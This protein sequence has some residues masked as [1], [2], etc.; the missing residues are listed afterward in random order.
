M[1]LPSTVVLALLAASAPALSVVRD[2]G[3]EEVYGLGREVAGNEVLEHIEVGVF[4][5]V[6]DSSDNHQIK[7][8]TISAQMEIV[9]NAFKVANISFVIK[10]METRVDPRWSTGYMSDM[11]WD[12]H[13]GSGRDLNLWILEKAGTDSMR[14]GSVT[15]AMSDSPFDETAYKTDGVVLAAIAIPNAPGWTENSDFQGKA[16]I[17]AIAKWFGLRSVFTMGC[18]SEDS[19]GRPVIDDVPVGRLPFRGEPA[20]A[21]VTDCSTPRDTCPEEPD[22]VK[23]GR[24][25]LAGPDPL[26]NYMSIHSEACRNRFSPNQIR[27]MHR[28]WNEFRANHT[29]LSPEK[30][31]SVPPV[32]V[33]YE[34]DGKMPYYDDPL[35]SVAH[36][37]CRPDRYGFVKIQDESRCGT[38]N[39]CDAQTGLKFDGM[40]NPAKARECRLQRARNPNAFWN[41]YIE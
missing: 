11:Q 14:R 18:S 36:R 1:L 23:R 16:A 35:S 29:A 15:H 20:E 21:K 38:W 41:D 9:N 33:K 27:L 8:E 32:E 19:W 10:D 13:K 7:N 2:L 25:N 5:H 3:N 34:E 17:R 26:D 6:V 22:A 28:N 31:E 30:E 12:T 40:D 37:F 24:K 4:V 39:F